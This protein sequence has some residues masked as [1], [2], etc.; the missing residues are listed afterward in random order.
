MVISQKYTNTKEITSGLDVLDYLY[1]NLRKNVERKEG[2][3]EFRDLASL[4][5]ERDAV[6]SVLYARIS[7]REV[8][9]CWLHLQWP[10]KALRSLVAIDSLLNLDKMSRV[11]FGPKYNT[12]LFLNGKKTE[13][14]TITCSFGG[15]PSNGRLS[16]EMVVTFKGSTPEDT[17]MFVL[18]EMLIQSWLPTL[19]NIWRKHTQIPDF[20]AGEPILLQGTLTKYEKRV[21]TGY[22][23]TLIT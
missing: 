18:P 13:D 23:R 6:F 16:R 2:S 22:L 1:R 21:L 15:F 8:R 4:L 20:R 10:S 3:S 17:L 5:K 11:K 9:H 12:L 7:S 19:Q 14:C